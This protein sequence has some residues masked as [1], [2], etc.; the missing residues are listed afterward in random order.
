[1]RILFPL[2]A[3]DFDPTETAIPWKQVREAGHEVVFATPEAEAPEADPR[4]LTGKGFGPWRFFLRAVGHT[5]EVYDEMSADPSFRA[6]LP[7]A[8]LD[9]DDFDGVFVTGGHAPGMKPYLESKI[10]HDLVAAHLLAGKPVGAICHGVLIPARARNP[11]TGRSILYGRKTTC[12]T[13][14]QELSAWSMTGLWLGSYYRTYP[15]PVEDEV[16]SALEDPAEDF[17][18][19]PFLLGREG[20]EKRDYGFTL[21]DGNYLS[22]RYFVDSYKFADDL[23]SLLADHA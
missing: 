7:Y 19:G 2:P 23:V 10:V 1:M 8:E 21:R 18:S 22:G 13:K 9:A 20:P 4:I 11:E 16:K 14:A 3:R 5:R 15:Q 6:P 12:L 17:V